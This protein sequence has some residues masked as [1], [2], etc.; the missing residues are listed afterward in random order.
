METPGDV[1]KAN[2]KVS[3]L[4]SKARSIMR[5]TP[6]ADV[7]FPNWHLQVKAALQT[8]AGKPNEDS[9]VQVSHMK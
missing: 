3:R 7:T 6:M 4:V 5:F 8:F 1:T 2:E 9:N